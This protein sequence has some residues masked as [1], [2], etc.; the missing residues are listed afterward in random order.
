MELLDALNWRYAAKKMNGQHVPEEKITNILKAIQLS[1]S[2]AGLQPY[3]VIVIS[4]P[5]LKAKIH[6][7]ACPQPQIVES[8]HVLVFAPHISIDGAYVDHYMQHIANER[9]IPVSSLA[10]FAD[11]VKGN[12]AAKSPEVLKDWNARQTYI[13]L[14]FGIIAAAVEQVDATPM[15]GFNAK[16][17]DEILGLKE[18]N[19]FSAAVLTLGYRDEAKDFLA[20][21]KKVRKE[22]AELFIHLN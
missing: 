21:A 4:N 20:T 2:S 1:A 12:L 14:G 17:L 16:V 22:E 5:A 15:E 8:S 18:K 19:L 9:N 11:S 13:A 3:Q 6:E 10:P 7:L